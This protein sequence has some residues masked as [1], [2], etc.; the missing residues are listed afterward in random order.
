RFPYTTRFRSRL[1]IGPSPP[2]FI[3]DEDWFYFSSNDG[4]H[5]MIRNS[6]E[7]MPYYHDRVVRHQTGL[8]T[9]KHNR[10]FSLRAANQKVVLITKPVRVAGR[11]LQLNVE[12]NRGLVR[13]AI[14][15]AEPV[16]TLNGTTLSMAPHLAEQKPLA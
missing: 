7:Q 13:V 15:S 16:A 1:V 6:P 2:L 5:L 10:Y 14:A 12:A 8:Y 9:Q 4:N 3:G 11:T